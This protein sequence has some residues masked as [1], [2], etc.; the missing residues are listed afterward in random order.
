M[1]KIKCTDTSIRYTSEDIL[2][3][4]IQIIDDYEKHGY[5]ITVRQ[6][7]YQ[8]VSRKIISNEISSYQK[9]SKLLTIGRMKGLID[10]DMIVDRVRVPIMPGQFYSM[11]MFIDGIKS[12][13]RKYRWDERPHY[14]EVMVEK[15]TLA[16]MLG[17]ITREYHVM[18]LV[19]K[20]YSSASVMHGV[21]ERMEKQAENDKQ[22]YILYMVD[23]NPGGMDMVR[24]IRDRLAGFGCESEAERIALTSAQIKQYR[25]P[26][27]PA[28]RSDPR[29]RKYAREY[30]N[31]SWELDALDPEVLAD[32]LESHILEYPNVSLYNGIL[33]EECRERKAPERLEKKL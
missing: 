32:V 31:K 30:G 6:L 5:S 26:P 19:N 10:W 9:T 25:P 22:C 4:M 21:A 3:K 15:E 29:S 14:L 13:Y 1:A 18:L 8:L 27:N 16:G 17:P 7:Y 24:D 11:S 20:G 33:A 28:K 23:H 12:V 2:G